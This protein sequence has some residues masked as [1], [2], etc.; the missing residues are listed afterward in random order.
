VPVRCVLVSWIRSE[1][2]AASGPAAAHTPARPLHGAG[3]CL[4]GVA[5]GP[6]PCNRGQSLV[7]MS[8]FD[9]RESKGMVVSPARHQKF[10]MIGI[11]LRRSW[12]KARP[13]SAAEHEGAC[14][15]EQLTAGPRLSAGPRNSYAETLNETSGTTRMPLRPALAAA[16]RP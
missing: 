11:L 3:I 10:T 12:R 1:R 6:R 13:L 14:R 9:E 16:A 15:P 2:D 5:Q 8:T 4:E 7:G